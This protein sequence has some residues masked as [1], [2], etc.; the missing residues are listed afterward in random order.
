MFKRADGLWVGRIERGYD[1]RGKRIRQTIYARTKTELLA[2]LR[3]AQNDAAHG[4]PAVD[5]RQTV[6]QYLEWWST[7]ILPGTVRPNSAQNYDTAIR[8]HINPSIG[9]VRLAKL[10]PEHVER[11]MRDLAGRG[12]KP[13]TV[14]YA[15]AVLRRALA[16]AERHGRVLRN[17]AALAEGPKSGGARLDDAPTPDEVKKILATSRAAQDRMYAF[18]VLALH[19]GLRRGE[20]LALRWEHVDLDAGTLTVGGTLTRINRVGLIINDPKTV[21]SERQLPLVDPCLTALREHRKQQA[22][23]RLAAPY[24]QDPGIVFASECGTWYDPRDLTR[25]WHALTTKAGVGRRRMHASRHAAATNMLAA[26]VPLEVVS[27]ILGHAGLAITADIYA[28][29]G[30][31]AKRRAL[32]TLATGTAAPTEH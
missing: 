26:G 2:K 18:A 24:W 6:R 7:T 27:A 5:Q 4:L 29:V 14:R 25:W 21:T 10:T 30:Q 8:C 17:A 23:E 1:T 22:K 16:T 31:D 15:R 28:K 20:L 32:E 19:L 13:S 11:M 12:L 3:N 9:N